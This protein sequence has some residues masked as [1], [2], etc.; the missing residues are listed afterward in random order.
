MEGWSNDMKPKTKTHLAVRRG[1]SFDPALSTARRLIYRFAAMTLAD[2]RYGTWEQLSVASTAQLLTQAAAVVQ[3]EPAAKADTLGLGERSLAQL[4]PTAVLQRLPA[5]AEAANAGYERVF[6]LLVSSNCPPY[7]TEYINS[8]F[9]FQR[10]QGLADIA[11]FY[12]AFGLE[13]S[14][15]QPERQDHLVLELEFMALLLSLER[16]AFKSNHPD[17]V[18][19]RAVCVDACRKFLNE[20]LIWWVPTFAHLLSKQDP[21]GFYGAVSTFLSALVAA[22]RSLTGLPLPSGR[23]APSTVERPEECEGCHLNT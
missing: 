6:G 11:G 4:D 19:R 7:E 3:N 14:A 21:S 23:V 20:H 13:P 15:V 22:E 8:K 12:R 1:E 17:R 2:P 5:S 18:A 9:A 10:S 16:A